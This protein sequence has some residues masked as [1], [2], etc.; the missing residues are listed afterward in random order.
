MKKIFNHSE[1][2]AT[3]LKFDLK[4]KLT[5]LLLFTA[6]VGLHANDS[7][8][9]KTK[10]TL[11][12]ENV[13]VQEIL[14]D[15]ESK[16]K[17]NFVYNTEH[18]NLQR[19]LSLHIQKEHIEKVLNRLFLNT[20][21]NYKVK[22]TQVVLW[23]D[24]KAKNAKK[25]IINPVPVMNMMVQFTVTGNVTDPD[26]IPLAGASILEKG[27]TNG[28]QTD[29]DGNFSINV[30]D[31]NA[32]LVSSYIGY[33]TQE[34]TLN[35]QTTLSIMLAESAV[36][37]DEIVVVGYGSV[38]K[39][40]LT[41]AVASISSEDLG[42][43][44]ATSVA[45]LIQGRAPGVDATGGKIR[46]R[47]ITT[48]NNTDPLVV[49][50]GFLGGDLSTVNPNDIENIEV[51]KDASS[52]AIYGSRG[53][54]GVILVTT[55]SGREGAMKVNVNFWSG[56][57]STTNKRDV[58]N[59]NQYIDYVHDALNNAGQNIPPKLLTD[60]VRI[61]RN[62]WQDLIFQTGH[63]SEVNASFSGGT[64]KA[65]YY[66]GVSHR[67]DENIII[68]SSNKA[69]YLRTKNSF[70]IK[71]WL[72]LNVNAALSYKTI[73]GA[74]PSYIGMLG[75]MPYKEIY[76]ENQIGGYTD[77]DRINDASDVSNPLTIPNKVN[78]ETNTLAYQAQLNLKI[79]PFK[80]FSY[81]IQAGLKGD[82][83]RFF[84]WQDEY[85]SAGSHNVNTMLESSSYFY[86]PI[87]ESYLNYTKQFGDH[88]VSALL[89]NTWQDGV[90]GGGIGIGATG[91]A[92]NE[93]KLL[94]VAGS[95]MQ[96]TQ[97]LFIDSR[98]SY[99]GRINYGFKSK[100][101]M[102]IN[103]RADAS[104]NFSP[105]NRWGKFPSLSL[106]WK[107]DEESFLR[108]NEV[109]NQLKLRAGWGKSGND[110]IGQY[111]Y[112][113]SVFSQGVGY[114]LGINQE[115]QQ[116]AS[117][118]QN[119]SPEIKWE[120]TESLTVGVDFGLFNNTLTGTVEYFEKQTD[121]ILFAV[122][123]PLSLGYGSGQD[124]GT[125]DGNAIVN[126]ASV[127]NKGFEFLLGKR[128]DIGE[129]ISYDI[130][131]NYTFQENV[132][133]GLGLGQPFLSG[134]SRTEKG[135]PIGY[136]Y[137]YEADGIYMTQA[138][139]DAANADAVANGHDYFQEASTS[140]GDVR[141]RDLSGDGK[142]DGDD[143]T[144][145]GNPIPKHLFGVNASLNIGQFD[146]NM[147]WQGAANVD[148]Y[149]EGYKWNR[150]GVRI[151]NQ[152]TIVLNR[153]RSESEP[154]NGV[155]PRALSGDAVANTRPSTLMVQDAGYL[156]LKLMSLGYTFSDE[157]TTKFGMSRF[158]LYASGE[159]L[160][161]LTKYDGFNPEIGGENLVR[162]VNQFTPPAARTVVLGIQ[163]SL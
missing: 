58:L 163:I 84:Q 90:Q 131:A 16:T 124:G 18:V 110:A 36:A 52:T 128:G 74:S 136:F 93:I 42:D 28:V 151:L 83:E 27:T 141:F 101:L 13:S 77:V 4:M 41:G 133:T 1:L 86:S 33:S 32:T 139:I 55:K 47:G 97:D 46:I 43:R 152:E 17:F 137:G 71:P 38:Q 147:F 89:G 23:R 75:Y 40:D 56:L 60:E 3:L 79:K 125:I 144:M 26:G 30:S 88:N 155:Q 140:A 130:S 134:V 122:P 80:G 19:K 148:I 8:A 24:Q 102:T 69:T 91:Y 129:K 12:V 159:N 61:D 123:S 22:G 104:P 54:N 135:R 160:L 64:E 2:S 156:R 62:D 70:E 6:L 78:P 158:R 98:L 34:I 153:W 82:F 81:T 105:N 154:G 10:V 121:D 50:D 65:T 92:T 66:F 120:T 49:I 115:Y 67:D 15:I 116:G 45:G 21:T 87:V 96:P 57:K 73:K 119:A 142:I 51:L 118:V 99:F 53:A 150:A 7:Y 94:S 109:I 29:F 31:A 157:L 11:N 103:M 9:Q 162:G 59:A 149:D 37:M 143:R 132:V 100:Y 117:V 72:D 113:S 39:S 14:D 68:G 5:V 111:R 126:A 85:V 112:L 76:D 63:S 108:D 48:F 95:P 35:G 145:I 114:P 106:A 44:Q 20:E 161:T 127:S 107:L 146:F 138:E 25:P